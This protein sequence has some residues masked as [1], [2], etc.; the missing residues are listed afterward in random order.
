MN[1]SNQKSRFLFATIIIAVSFLIINGIAQASV[2]QTDDS[3]ASSSPMPIW[4]Q[5]LGNGLDFS[6][7]DLTIRVKNQGDAYYSGVLYG[8]PTADYASGYGITPIEQYNLYS[9]GHSTF[10]SGFDDKITLTA[11]LNWNNNPTLSSFPLNP[12]RYYEILLNAGDASRAFSIYG[13]PQDSY[14]NGKAYYSDF[15]THRF[16][17]FQPYFNPEEVCEPGANNGI[18]DIYFF[19]EF[20]HDLNF[21]HRRDF[22]IY[23]NKVICAAN[24]GGS[25]GGMYI[26]L[27]DLATGEEKII[28][29]VVPAMAGVSIFENQIVWS[30][31]YDIFIYDIAT[32]KTGRT[33]MAQGAFM[34]PKI[35][36]D[37]VVWY[38]YRAVTNERSII[39]IYMYQIASQ[40][41]PPVARF[42]FS[43]QN[44]KAGDNVLFD[45]SSSYDPDGT[46]ICYGWDWDGN[47]IIDVYS[48]TPF[49]SYLWTFDGAYTVGLYVFNDKNVTASTS[50]TITTEK[51]PTS[52]YSANIR[53]ALLQVFGLKCGNSVAEDEKLMDEIDAWIRDQ[54]GDG[55]PDDYSPYDWL[56]G[57]RCSG[58]GFR[59]IQKHCLAS[60]LNKEMRE[61]AEITYKDY[62]IAVIREQQLVHKALLK[63]AKIDYPLV[64]MFDFLPSIPS[65]FLNDLTSTGVEDIIEKIFNA[66]GFADTVGLFKFGSGGLS[67]IFKA[68]SLNAIT[69]KIGDNVYRR[70][71]Y[72]YF[73]SRNVNNSPEIAW[74]S[75]CGVCRQSA[76][77]ELESYGFSGA[78]LEE[79]R[80]KF[81]DWWQK[82]YINLQSKYGKTETGEWNWFNGSGLPPKFNQDLKNDVKALILFAVKNK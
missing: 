63:G 27:H 11:L 4:Q 1:L 22:D 45:A 8:F 50:Q 36:G 70:A 12:N 48:D 73:Y 34:S 47:G 19:I 52:I 15:W 20:F 33:G 67:L 64:V 78:M 37:T 26:M 7:K 62:I 43:P 54:D 58:A 46:V 76:K 55:K 39:D 42:E 71:L 31:A 75:V 18:E 77:T 13:S 59:G 40:N 9:M 60:A 49:V 38:D 10:P 14:P 65:I 41:N 81:E 74:Q 80:I 2:Q 82:Y 30:D 35:S 6:V 57:T 16:C 68:I 51:S 69:N 56:R 23:G 66:S 44:P 25:G 61:G 79:S 53:T 72:E 21:R 17:G 24:S 5:T 29:P 3:A 28:N 32:G